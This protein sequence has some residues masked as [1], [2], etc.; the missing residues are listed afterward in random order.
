MSRVGPPFNKPSP[1]PQNVDWQSLVRLDGDELEA[2]DRHVL[3]SLGK[4]KGV[5]GTPLVNLE[6]PPEGSKIGFGVR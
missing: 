5:L 1:I 2:H 4:E 3:E 6:I